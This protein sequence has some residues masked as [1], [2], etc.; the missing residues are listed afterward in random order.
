MPTVVYT[1]ANPPG[2]PH[3]QIFAA[4]GFTLRYPPP[5]ADLFVEDELIAVLHDADAVLAG[6]EPYTCRVLEALPRLRVI[7]RAGVGFDAVDLQACDRARIP[8]CTTPGV[9]HHSVAEHTISLLMGVAR[10]FPLLDQKVRRGDWARK[11]YPRVM[12]KTL[13]LIGMGRIGQATATRARGLEMHVIAHDP[14]ADR[15]FARRHEIELVSLDELLPRADFV[16]LHLPITPETNRFMNR[17]RFA[18]MKPGAI[19]LNTS[20][21]P[22]V[23]EEALYDA[24]KSGHLGGAGLDVFQVEPLPLDSPLLTLENVLVSG[25]VAG[26]DD[27]SLH[28]TNVMAAETIVALF[29]GRWP[30]GC[31]QNLKGTTQWTWES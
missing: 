4:A 19:F 25:H 20:R 26:L 9:N 30:A 2:G 24:L 29:Q 15:D 5:A 13:G 1:A 8:V 16:S 28:D 22:L 18:R 17:D 3:E 7:A 11:P 31:V 21:G 23:D 6:S 10:G 14:F 12:G 27:Q